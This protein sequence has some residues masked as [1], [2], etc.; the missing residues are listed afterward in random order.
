MLSYQRVD[1]R[2]I[3]VPNQVHD[4][5]RAQCHSAMLPARMPLR[6]LVPFF[7]WQV[8]QRG[9]HWEGGGGPN[10][11]G[12]ADFLSKTTTSC[13]F[14]WSMMI[15]PSISHGELAGCTSFSDTPISSLSLCIVLSSSQPG[16]LLMPLVWSLPEALVTAE[17]ATTFPSNAGFVETWI[18]W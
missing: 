18:Y 6:R 16:F 11:F 15:F 8:P 1:I 13:G 17:L 2:R 5:S 12:S 10:P 7:L 14:L 4:I 3:K 9:G